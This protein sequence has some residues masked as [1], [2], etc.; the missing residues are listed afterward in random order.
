MIGF[1]THHEAA[2]RQIESHRG[3][4]KSEDKGLE[5]VGQGGTLWPLVKFTNGSERLCV[6]EE[7]TVNDAFGNVEASRIQVREHDISLVLLTL[8]R[9]H[10]SSHGPSVCTS[11][12]VR[13][14]TGSESTFA[15][16]LRRVKV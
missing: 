6:P 13:H 15:I 2:L 7:F 5:S 9:Y 11:P 10:S 1:G 14:W 8:V 3:D 4:S 16:L 12:R